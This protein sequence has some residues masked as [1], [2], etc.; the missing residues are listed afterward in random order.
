MP[1]DLREPL[2]RIDRSR[3]HDAICTQERGLYGSVLLYNKDGVLIK[4]R[5]IMLPR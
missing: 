5:E 1:F 3:K 2:E 4:S